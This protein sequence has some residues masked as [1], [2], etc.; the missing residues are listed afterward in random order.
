MARRALITG[1]AGQDGSYLTELLLSKG[2][3]VY[4]IAG[5]APLDL[6][7]DAFA[8]AGERLQLIPGDLTDIDSLAQALETSRPD[9]IYNLAALSGVGD[10]WE[11]ALV[12][13]DVNALGT[14]RLL[15]A[16][17]RQAPTARLMVPAS[18]EIFGPSHGAPQDEA[19][20]LDPRSPY[21]ASKAYAYSI[22]KVYRQAHG[23]Y[24]SNAVLFNHESPRRPTSVVTRKITDAA[25]RI[26]L[27][28][29]DSV[30]LGNLEARRA[31]GFAGD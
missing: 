3:T 17:R 15:E 18:A 11:Q 8:Q 25:A 22:G 23:V 6:L 4:G 20:P 19:S 31:W 1:I 12:S 2:Y 27:G 24:C 9:E 30:A 14:L 26:S 13:A 21:G 5:P 28:L 16:L 10:S 29:A 7:A